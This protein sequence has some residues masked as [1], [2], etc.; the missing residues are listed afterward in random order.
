MSNQTPNSKEPKVQTEEGDSK[1]VSGPVMYIATFLV[2][3][4]LLAWGAW[5]FSHEYAAET[6][7][8]WL[9]NFINQ[10][11]QAAT[12]AVGAGLAVVGSFV[13]AVLVFILLLLGS[14]AWHRAKSAFT[15]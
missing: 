1:R 13:A 11:S 14:I 15:R 7:M 12:F 2:A 3:W 8:P 6:I 4:P 9:M 5:S 10:S